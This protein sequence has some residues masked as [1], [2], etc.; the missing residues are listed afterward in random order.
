MDDDEEEYEE[1]DQRKDDIECNCLCFTWDDM[2]H[3]LVGFKKKNNN[4]FPTES[5]DM[6]V[7]DIQLTKLIQ[8]IDRQQYEYAALT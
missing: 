7:Y 6:K 5:R 2:F 4:H 8:W 1:E 3:K